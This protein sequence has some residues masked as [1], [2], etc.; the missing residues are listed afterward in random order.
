MGKSWDSGTVKKCWDSKTV[1]QWSI[2]D[3]S[4]TVRKSCDSET[5]LAG[6]PGI[7]PQV[8]PSSTWERGHFFVFFDFLIYILDNRISRS[9]EANPC[10]FNFDNQ[11][12]PPNK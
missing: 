11:K 10:R 12:E 6:I 8:F 5:N 1:G 3:D 7:N 2:E 9:F 4:E